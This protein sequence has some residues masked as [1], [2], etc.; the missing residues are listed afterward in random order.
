LT[1]TKH[2]TNRGF[3]FGNFSLV[4]N[5]LKKSVSETQMKSGKEMTPR[6]VLL[7]PEFRCPMMIF[8]T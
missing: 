5:P 6:T 1:S 7:E 3:R 4:L 8:E 2:G